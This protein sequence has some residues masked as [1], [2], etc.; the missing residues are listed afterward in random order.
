MDEKGFMIGQANKQSRIVPILDI[1]RSQAPLS[2]MDGCREWVTL[3]ACICGDGTAIKPTLM[4]E[5]A[6]N[7]GVPDSWLPE[8]AGDDDDAH[9]G[10][11]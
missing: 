5:G 11:S 2:R 1:Q 9:S 10:R 6:R 3:L 7:K 8:E 4:I